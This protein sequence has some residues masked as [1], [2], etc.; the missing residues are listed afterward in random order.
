MGWTQT[1]N[2]CQRFTWLGLWG[3]LLV[4]RYP[5]LTGRAGEDGEAWEWGGG[6]GSH[7]HQ[8]AWACC[9]GPP[10]WLLHPKAR[11]LCT[12]MWM[13]LFWIISVDFWKTRSIFQNQCH[14]SIFLHLSDSQI[15]G[16]LI[17]VVQ[18]VDKDV[19]FKLTVSLAAIHLNIMQNQQDPCHRSMFLYHCNT[20]YPGFLYCSLYTGMSGF[21]LQGI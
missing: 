9:P 12:W 21:L 1:A 18:S 11:P 17:F 4:Q 7:C 19:S 10:Y 13:F 20:T 2:R 15:I 3:L 5:R 8:S 14:R 16:S 6:W